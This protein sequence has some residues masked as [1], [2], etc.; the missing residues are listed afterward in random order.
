MSKI[1]NDALD[2]LVEMA[3]RSP[4]STQTAFEVKPKNYA[5]MRVLKHLG[6]LNLSAM[7]DGYQCHITV[8]GYLAAEAHADNKL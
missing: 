2:F 8:E 1:T 4:L 5:S 3:D 6:Y 7:M